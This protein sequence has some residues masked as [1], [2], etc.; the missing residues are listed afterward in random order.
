MNV[1]R[2]DKELDLGVYSQSSKI[3]GEIFINIFWWND[4][5]KKSL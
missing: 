4:S 1:E 5:G 3:D 2:D